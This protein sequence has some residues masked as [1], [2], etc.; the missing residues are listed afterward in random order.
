MKRLSE[1]QKREICL[2]FYSGEKTKSELARMFNVS[3]TAISKIL[4]DDKVASSFKKL[5]DETS[6]ECVMSMIAFMES[7]NGQAQ[8]IIAAIMD[9]LQ[10]TIV[11]KM[12]KSSLKDCVNAIE[13]LSK[14]FTLRGD[15][16]KSDKEA[17]AEIVNAI[18]GVAQK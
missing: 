1:K 2:Q 15:S 13:S 3:H 14:T 16:E 6:T 12:K 11:E 5:S 7:K 10:A 8:E 17:L 9:E 4:S 18:N